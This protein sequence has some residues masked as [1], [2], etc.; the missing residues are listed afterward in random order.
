MIGFL[1]LRQ[2]LLIMHAL[3]GNS[4]KD[5]NRPPRREASQIPIGFKRQAWPPRTYGPLDGSSR[6]RARRLI[7]YAST[8]HQTS[9]QGILFDACSAVLR[10]APA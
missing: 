10:S 2:A 7:F 5:K 3:A 1:F 8:D 6:T 4:Q 9:E